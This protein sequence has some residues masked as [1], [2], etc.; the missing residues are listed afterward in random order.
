MEIFKNLRAMKHYFAELGL[1]HYV[2]AIGYVVTF[3]I[4]FM[5]WYS[6]KNPVFLYVGFGLVEG[7]VV[8]GALLYNKYGRVLRHEGRDKMEEELFG[9]SMDEL[10][11]GK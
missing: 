6:T 11:G 7:V 5:I 2:N 3:G 4:F 10:R 9:Q 1:P 8:S